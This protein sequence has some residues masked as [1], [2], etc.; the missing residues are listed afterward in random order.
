MCVCVFPTKKI[1]NSTI[2]VTNVGDTLIV[3]TNLFYRKRGGSVD[4][5]LDDLGGDVVISSGNPGAI[6]TV[7]S[8]ASKKKSVSS[9][10]LSM[11]SEQSGMKIVA[12]S[13]TEEVRITTV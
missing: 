2:F 11:G 12:S 13:D 8:Q 6:S 5:L 1:T 4:N 10:N 3:H 9:K 7:M